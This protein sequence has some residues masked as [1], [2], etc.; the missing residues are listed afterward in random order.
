MNKKLIK[1][2]SIIMF[3]IIIISCSLNVFAASNPADIPIQT[4]DPRNN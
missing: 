1:I 2:F 3:A 4:T